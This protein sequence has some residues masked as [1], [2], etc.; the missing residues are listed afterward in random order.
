LHH[1]NVFHD[2]SHRN[3]DLALRNLGGKKSCSV[4]FRSWRMNFSGDSLAARKGFLPVFFFVVWKKMLR[5][6]R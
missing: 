6:K 4:F 3:G 5:T 2:S 1:I